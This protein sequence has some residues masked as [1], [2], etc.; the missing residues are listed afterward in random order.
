MRIIGRAPLGGFVEVDGKRLWHLQSGTGCPAVVFLP[1]A[2]SFGLDFFLVHQL[3]AEQTTSLLYDR[4][5]TGWSDDA[6][7]PRS[8]DE[9]TDELRQLL[10]ALAVRA[11]LLLVGHSLGGAYAQRY[12]QRFPHDVAG[13]L[14]LDPLHEDWDDYMPPHLKLAANVSDGSVM[15]ELPAEVVDQLRMVMLDWMAGFPGPLREAVVDRHASADRLLTGFREGVNVLSILDELRTGGP[16]PDIPATILSA[17]GTDDMQRTLAGADQLRE[18]IEG[19]ERLFAT[20]AAAQPHW[21]HE[22]LTDASHTTLPMVRPDGVAEAVL[23]LINRSGLSGEGDDT[24]DEMDQL[25]RLADG[26]STDAVDQL[27]ELAGERGDLAELRRL[28]E[29]GSTDAADILVEL[30]GERG[31]MAELRRLADGGNTDARDILAELNESDDGST[32]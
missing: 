27:V 22:T 30:A 25:R 5:G 6:T 21:R 11:P 32:E 24:R 10:D 23:D 17:T 29:R 12:A 18:Q 7:L 31:D 4:A 13:L 15:P 14:L 26:G 8:L 3:V 28:A 1:G 9:V 20:V 19:S 2:G 16:R